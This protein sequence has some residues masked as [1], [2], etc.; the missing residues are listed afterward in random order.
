MAY[1]IN[2]KA[3]SRIEC[4]HSLLKFLYQ[5]FNFASFTLEDCMFSRDED[6]IHSYC[7]LIEDTEFGY[8]CPF[9]ESPLSDAGCY[10]TNGKEEDTTKKKELDNSFELV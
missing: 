6:N 8:K 9:K 7:S 5:N 4:L 1:L 3:P 10:I 2:R